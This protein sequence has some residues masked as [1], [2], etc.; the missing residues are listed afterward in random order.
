MDKKK[1]AQRLYLRHFLTGKLLTF[2]LSKVD[3]ENYIM[4]CLSS[5]DKEINQELANVQ[6]LSTNMMDQMYWQRLR[7]FFLVCVCVIFYLW[8]VLPSSLRRPTMSLLHIF[9]IILCSLLSA[10]LRSS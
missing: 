6:I 1:S 7:F 8:G 9:P 3:D 10:S 4:C 2:R 5:D